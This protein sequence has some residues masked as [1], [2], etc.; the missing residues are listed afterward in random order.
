VL[1]VEFGFSGSVEVLAVTPRNGFFNAGTTQ[2]PS[3]H[4]ATV[5]DCWTIPYQQVIA[6]V[7]VWI[8][9]E[10]GGNLCFTNSEESGANCAFLCAPLGQYS[11]VVNGYRYGDGANCPYVNSQCENTIPVEPATWG[12][13]KSAYRSQ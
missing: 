7:L 8:E 1:G 3:L 11:H 6:E 5:D 12:R 2:S 4:H 9:D 10:A 13:I